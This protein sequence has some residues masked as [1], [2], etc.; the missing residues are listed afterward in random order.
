MMRSKASLCTAAVQVTNDTLQIEQSSG[1]GGHTAQNVT[2]TCVGTEMQMLQPLNVGRR[3]P[4]SLTAFPSV[5]AS[6]DH[7][8]FPLWAIIVLLVTSMHRPCLPA[9]CITPCDGMA[10]HLVCRVDMQRATFAACI[11][12]REVWCT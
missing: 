6:S 2:Y 11:L 4:D 10:A 12:S 5:T 3:F 1:A 8:A 7:K 9:D